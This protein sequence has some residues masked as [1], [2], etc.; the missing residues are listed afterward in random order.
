MRTG[1]RMGVQAQPESAR[2]FYTICARDAEG[3]PEARWS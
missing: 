3:L 1:I 2:G